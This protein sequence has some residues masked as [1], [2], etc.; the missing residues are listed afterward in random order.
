M[1]D[2]AV[3]VRTASAADVPAV[4]ALWAAAGYARDETIARFVRSV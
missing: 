2:P 4:L 3:S 1:S